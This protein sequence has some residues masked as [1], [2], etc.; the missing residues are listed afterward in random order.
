MDRND[1]SRLDRILA[2]GEASS[3]RI[4]SPNAGRVANLDARTSRALLVRRAPVGPVGQRKLDDIRR[5]RR[6][7]DGRSRPGVEDCGAPERE[8]GT[9]GVRDGHVMG[10]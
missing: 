6:H 2:V 10:T 4:E 3:V 9:D 8:E 5:T 7:L 1:S